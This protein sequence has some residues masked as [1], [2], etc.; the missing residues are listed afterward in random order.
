MVQPE[1]KIIRC[2]NCSSKNIKKAGVRSGKLLTFQKYKCKSCQ[3][4]FTLQALTK[5]KTYP[6]KVILNSLSYYNLGHTQIEIVK[7]ISKRFRIKP[8]QKTISNWLNEYKPLTPFFRLRNRVKKLYNPGTIVEKHPL[9]HNNLSYK[10]QY[11]RAKL[12]LLFRDKLYNNKFSDLTKFEQPLRRYL[13]KIP[14]KDFPHHIF[15]KKEP[16]QEDL[17]RSSQLKFKILPLLKHSKYNLANKLASLALNLATT[18][19][20]RHQVIQD[21]MLINDSTTIAT[22]IPVYLTKYDISY[23]KNKGF[24]LNLEG[25]I[26]PITG[27]I[28]I[29]QARNNLIHI[30]DY[31]PEAQK[32]NPINQ[33]I[34]YA[35]ALASRTKLA[36]KDFK[37]AWFDENNYFEFF[38]L[39][40]VLEPKK[41]AKKRI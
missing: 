41:Q 15:E 28:D 30:L 35:L 1:I 3:K 27:H 39:L 23:L 36:I 6:T 32:I 7:I 8:T 20:Q 40:A 16:S 34:I 37:C 5:N 26:T 14:T 2:P 25:Q 17:S 18:N 24:K 4:I 10:F 22:E 13:H 38:P 21:F 31:K 9:T 12:D 11:H 33:L 29:L 19:K